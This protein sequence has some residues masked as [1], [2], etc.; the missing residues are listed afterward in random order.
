MRPFALRDAGYG[1]SPC[2][3]NATTGI[4]S[5][6]PSRRSTR[7]A[8]PDYG[9]AAGGFS[10][11]LYGTSRLRQ[12]F[13]VS[14][15]RIARPG[16]GSCQRHASSMAMPGGVPKARN[17]GPQARRAIAGPARWAGALAAPSAP[18]E[19][20]TYMATIKGGRAW[21]GCAVLRPALARRRNRWTTKDSGRPFSF[22]PGPALPARLSQPESHANTSTTR[23][24]SPTGAASN[25]APNP[26]RRGGG[27]WWP[28][29]LGFFFGGGRRMSR[30][31]TD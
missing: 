30:L 4:G 2:R 19:C 11:A 27:A 12:H 1:R 28:R 26:V 3:Q 7:R 13:D 15:C 14:R 6:G 16:S 10:E 18:P 25:P 8:S 9:R 29:T 21:A 22:S 23:P 24:A 20:N 17:Q 5:A 31:T